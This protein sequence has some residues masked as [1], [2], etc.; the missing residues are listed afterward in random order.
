M[1]SSPTTSTSTSTPSARSSG[2]GGGSRRRPGA[3]DRAPDQPGRRRRLQRE[4]GLQRGAADEV[5]DLRDRVDEAVAVAARHGLAIDTI[6]VHAGSGWLADGLPAFETALSGVAAIARRLVADG[7]PITEL[8]VGG[9]LGVPA[10]ADE[11]PVDLDAYA[12]AIAR[13]LDAARRRGR[14]RA[15]RL[16]R[17]GH[18]VLLAEVVTVEERGGTTFVGLDAGWNVNCSY[19]IYR[20]AQ[21]L[22]VCRAADAARTERVT[23][24]GHINEAGDVFAEDYDLPPVARGRHRRAA[25]RRR[26]PPG[27]ELDPLP[28]TPRR[29]ACLDR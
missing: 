16:P 22:V 6:H 2:S 14:L 18:G 7:H 27:D 11:T 24:A 23:V 20:Y 4:A 3:A 15:R 28:S 8:N 19:F 5:R 10:R 25:Q 12:A 17:E 26:L 1:R 9:G 13:Q 21:E 29:G